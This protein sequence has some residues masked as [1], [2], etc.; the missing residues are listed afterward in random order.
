[1]GS[2]LSDKRVHRLP[3]LCGS[4]NT[5]AEGGREGGSVCVSLVTE[6]EEGA[7]QG[8]LRALFID[9]EGKLGEIYCSSSWGTLLHLFD[10]KQ[11]RKHHPPANSWVSTPLAW[12]IFR[13]ELDIPVSSPVSP[14]QG[15]RTRLQQKKRAAKV[16]SEQRKDTVRYCSTV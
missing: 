8:M 12:N 7:S 11:A 10:R 1:M 16:D 2:E 3:S 13:V 4:W 9:R 15:M 14:T 5:T 6:V